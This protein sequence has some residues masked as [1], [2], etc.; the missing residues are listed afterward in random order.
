MPVLV[1]QEHENKMHWLSKEKLCTSKENGGLGFRDL[2][3]FNLAILARQGWRLLANPESLCAKVLR[4]KYF[5]DGNL[6]EVLEYQ[7]YLTPGVA[8]SKGYE[9]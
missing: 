6:L 5:P 7:A 9:H 1:Q 8:L 4:A 2:H 3:L